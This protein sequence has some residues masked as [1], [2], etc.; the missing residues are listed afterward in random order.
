VWRNLQF[1]PKSSNMRIELNA[2]IN[3]SSGVQIFAESFITGFILF[4]C[5]MMRDL[6]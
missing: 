5:I 6:D 1:R 2:K 4:I 3:S